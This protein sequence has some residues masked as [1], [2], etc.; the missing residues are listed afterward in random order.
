LA[1]AWQ[2]G[3][4]PNGERGLANAIEAVAETVV[5]GLRL[6]ERA[7]PVVAMRV[8]LSWSVFV[9]R[10]AREGSA[11]ALLDREM[12]GEEREMMRSAAVEVTHEEVWAGS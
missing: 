8:L 12:S 7:V 9:V 1:I 10:V 6:S 3:S 11:S 4:T 2:D 5:A